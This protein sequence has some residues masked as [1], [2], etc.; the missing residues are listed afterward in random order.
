M[1]ISINHEQEFL[2]GWKHLILV[3]ERTCYNETFLFKMQ[4][5]QVGFIR[6]LPYLLICFH[7]DF[8]I[9]EK[10]LLLEDLYFISI[11]P[12][13]A[14]FKKKSEICQEKNLEE[15]IHENSSVG[16][17]WLH[18]VEVVRTLAHD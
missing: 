18:L 17:I 12:S 8:S 7:S 4:S 9:S 15:N 5:Q 1:S 16:S 3:Y 6:K 2:N 10:S 13:V 14:F 11:I